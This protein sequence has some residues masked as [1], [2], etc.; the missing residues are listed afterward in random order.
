MQ[1]SFFTLVR[2][3]QFDIVQFIKTILT[4]HI[5]ILYWYLYAYL[6]FLMMLPFLRRLAQGMEKS[7]VNREWILCCYI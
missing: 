3:Q 2:N 5:I 1:Q 6:A 7:V 4:G